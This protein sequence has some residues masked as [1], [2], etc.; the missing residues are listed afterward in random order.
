MNSTQTIIKM[1]FDRWYASL[2]NCD[3][4]LNSITDE[5]LQKEV[6]LNKNRGIYL[7]GHLIAVHDDMI[8]LLGMGDKLYPELHNPFIDSPDK[9]ATQI[10]S[11]K[12]LRACWT[13]QCDVL[14]QKLDSLQ[15]DEWFEKHTAVSAEDFIKEPHRNKLNII[16]T[17]TTHLAYHTGQ[18]VLLK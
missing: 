4:L 14:K 12:E 6:S 13:K 2:K 11:A 7:L 10:P 8:V 18:L 3:A 5:Q 9:T 17:R 1:V 16:I 15:P